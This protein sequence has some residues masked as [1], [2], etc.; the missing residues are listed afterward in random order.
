M[1]TGGSYDCDDVMF[2]L[3]RLDRP[4]MRLG[5]SGQNGK[6]VPIYFTDPEADAP[7]PSP[8]SE[9]WIQPS[10]DRPHWN[11][12]LDASQEDVELCEDGE[13]T[14]ARDGGIAIPVVFCFSDDGPWK[15]TKCH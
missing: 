2:A 4:E 5:T 6:T 8:G 3:V 13:T 12:V 10:I 15:R 14:I 7:T 9:V 1:W 11:D